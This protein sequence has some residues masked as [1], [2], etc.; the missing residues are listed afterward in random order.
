MAPAAFGIDA[1]AQGVH[2]GVE[3]GA[4]PDAVHP[5]VV[6]DVHDRGE[7]MLAV[8]A[9]K[10]AQAQQVLYPQQKPGAS[11]AA[12]QNGDLHNVRP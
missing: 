6:A 12:D 4:D 2:A 7:F 9:G 8:A 3:V 1:A 10:L 11:D 5:G